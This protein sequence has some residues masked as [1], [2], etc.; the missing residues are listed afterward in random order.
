M[1]LSQAGP[2]G[3]CPG[4]SLWRASWGVGGDTARPVAQVPAPTNRTV[5][6]EPSVPRRGGA[7]E[8]HLFV[9][10]R[11]SLYPERAFPECWC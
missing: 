9:A 5:N 3:R 1:G 6:S 8:E 10:K 11:G 2:Q 4:L 7:V